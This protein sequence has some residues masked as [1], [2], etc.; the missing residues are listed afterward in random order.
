[1]TTEATTPETTATGPAAVDAS[2][3]RNDFDI[4]G[5]IHH[6][7]KDI[8]SDRQEKILRWVCESLDLKLAAEP[9]PNA[10]PATPADEEEQDE[11]PPA[12]PSSATDIKSFVSEKK[13]RSDMQFAAVAAYYH[14]FVAPKDRRKE[15]IDAKELQESARQAGRAVLH[16]PKATLNN[17]H[18][19]GYLD[20]AERGTF[21][22]STV[23]ENLVA[24][25]LPGKG[26][27]RAKPAKRKPKPTK[28]R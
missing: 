9:A 21:K 10:A 22:I 4:A 14:R 1:M 25:T 5:E 11:P 17:A 2:K 8:P 16:S 7:L 23:G 15:T 19:S 3:I 28:K 13:P 26:N 18:A 20:R 24:M 27:D 6:V 12:P